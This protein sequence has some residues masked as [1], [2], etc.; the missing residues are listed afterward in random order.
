MWQTPSRVPPSPLLFLRDTHRDCFS[1]PS[2]EAGAAACR[3]SDQQNT[4][5]GTTMFPGL[6]LTKLTSVLCSLLCWWTQQVKGRWD[7][8]SLSDL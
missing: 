3:H 7:S 1:W 4:G 8:E 2:L 5:K 6:V